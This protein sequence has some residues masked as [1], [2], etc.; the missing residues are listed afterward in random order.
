MEKINLNKTMQ[1]LGIEELLETSFKNKIKIMKWDLKDNLHSF[2]F[3]QGY[4]WYIIKGN[5]IT[6]SYLP[7]DKEILWELNEGEWLGL[8]D[9]ILNILPEHDVRILRGSLVLE[10]PLW[11]ILNSKETP[12]SFYKKIITDF[13]LTIRP[14]LK[15]VGLKIKCHDEIYFLKYLERKNYEIQFQSLK[16]LSETLNINLRTFHRILKI[17]VAENI[18]FKEVDRIKVIDIKKLENYIEEKAINSL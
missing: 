15:N 1:S 7:G 18:I 5:L 3:K 17:L 2:G 14:V 11:E 9:A 12:K 4:A 13:A 6:T 10:I 8:P 16:E